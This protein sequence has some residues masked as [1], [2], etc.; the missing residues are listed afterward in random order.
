MHGRADAACGAGGDY[1]GEPA[2]PDDTVRRD[3]AVRAA[4]ATDLRVRNDHGDERGHA[5]GRHRVDPPAASAAG[6]APG[7]E[8]QRRW[9]SDRCMRA[10]AHRAR[11][12]A[13]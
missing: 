6:H 9:P 13:P 1:D 3:A 7:S 2:G 11:T 12:H 10:R 5:A 8:Q 4:A